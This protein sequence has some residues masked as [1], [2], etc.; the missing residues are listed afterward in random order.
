MSRAGTDG[1]GGLARLAKNASAVSAPPAPSRAPELRQRTCLFPEPVA[2]EPAH[3]QPEGTADVGAGESA[4]AGADRTRESFTSVFPSHLG[5]RTR[6][7]GAALLA[8][9][10]DHADL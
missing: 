10:E 5:E 8:V 3:N 1:R 9:K 7:D 6:E 4:S 2:D